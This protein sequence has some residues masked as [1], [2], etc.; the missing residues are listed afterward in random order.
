LRLF[1]VGVIAGAIPASSHAEYAVSIAH[2]NASASTLHVALTPYRPTVTV[3]YNQ[4]SDTDER[5]TITK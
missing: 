3:T 2:M 1:Y 5:R 4:L